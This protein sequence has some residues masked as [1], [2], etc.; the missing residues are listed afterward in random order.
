MVMMNALALPSESGGKREP[1]TT[2]HFG[3]LV[4]A[5]ACAL[6]GR[7]H[8]RNNL[9]SVMDVIDLLRRVRFLQGHA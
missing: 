9:S 2:S 4:V 6:E 8:G 3:R 1:W 7:G 5:Y